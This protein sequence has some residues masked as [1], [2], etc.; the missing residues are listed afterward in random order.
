[1][2]M[3]LLIFLIIVGI[4]SSLLYTYSEDEQPKWWDEKSQEFEE[5]KKSNPNTDSH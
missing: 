1:M 5:L 2:R 4:V 3:D